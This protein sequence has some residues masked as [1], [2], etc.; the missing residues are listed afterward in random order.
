MVP[1]MSLAFNLLN[2]YLQA[3]LGSG[4]AQSG[5]RRVQGV[6]GSVVRVGE[7][8]ELFS[9]VCGVAGLGRDDVILRWAGPFFST[10]APTW[11]LV[12]V[13]LISG[14]GRSLEMIIPNL[15]KLSFPFCIDYY[16]CIPI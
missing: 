6:E 12:H 9:G 2:S 16:A 7:L 14:T 1:L 13:G 8:S 4:P 15:E 11:C 10:R 3:R 5:R